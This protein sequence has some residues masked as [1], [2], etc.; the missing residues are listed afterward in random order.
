MLTSDKNKQ[1]KQAYYIHIYF[2]LRWFC[3]YNFSS[4]NYKKINWVMGSCHLYTLVGYAGCV[5]QCEG[6]VHQLLYSPGI[7][8]QV[9]NTFKDTA[10]RYSGI[11][12]IY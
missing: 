7:Y 1:R 2:M 5:I 11:S 12:H 9:A 8:L 10:L 3:T 6:S 4:Q